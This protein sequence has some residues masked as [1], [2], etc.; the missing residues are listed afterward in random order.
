M[1]TTPHQ[2]KRGSTGTNGRTKA[3][4]KLGHVPI[5]QMP[6]A[7]L[8]PAKVNDVIYRPVDPAAPDVQELAKSIRK[9]GL[10]EPLVIT[11]DNIILS[12]HRRRV[13]CLLARLTVVP[14]RRENVASTDPEFLPLLVEYNRQRVKSLDEVFREEALSVDPDAA[15][16]EL[17]SYRKQAARVAVDTIEIEGH[18]RRAKIS[19]AKQPFLDAIQ[20]ILDERRDFWPL[21]DRAIHYPLLNDPPL[22]HA[23]KPHS[24]YC[25]TVPF[26]K[27]TCELLTRARLEGII[28]WNAIHDPTR[29]VVVWEVHRSTGPFIQG[30]LDNF[31]Q[32]YCRDLLQS[33]PNHIEIVGEKNTIESVIRP[34]A[35]EHCIPYTIGRG[36]SGI[37]ARRKLALRFWKSGKEKLILLFMNDFDP[38][39]EDI[40]H[41]FARS[42]RDDFGIT[43]IVP[44]KVALTAEQVD[45]MGLPPQMKAKD[46]SSRA[47]KFT[48][49]HGDDVFELEAVPPDQLQDILTEGIDSV[50]DIDAYNHEVEEEK[51]D[52]AYLAVVRRHFRELMRTNPPPVR[53]AT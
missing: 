41:S 52:A 1:S 37:D 4:L 22:T 53:P 26:Y 25:N 28:P 16:E 29:P 32:G 48:E 36:Y 21:T 20:R 9:K 42:M 38:E 23:S 15:Y 7:A 12:G 19:K 47:A 50:L 8:S 51:K 5:L 13:A 34:V 6:L 33:Q 24:I 10:L 43:K 44:V 14:C 18:K 40:P 11:T 39:G 2:S 35:M 30:A 17:L 3:A 49:R 46:T 27:Q 45:E 31:L